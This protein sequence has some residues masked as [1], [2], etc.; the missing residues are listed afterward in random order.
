MK[1]LVLEDYRKFAYK[2]VP[3]PQIEPENVL[4]RVA[5]CAICGSDVHGMDGSTG[6]RI[7]PVIMG[8]EASGIIEEMG[9][10]VKDFKIGDR[11]TFD[12]NV[13]CG[14]CRYCR[15]G[16]PNLCESRR[17]LGVSC[18]EYRQDG[19]FAEYLSVP[20]R[21]LCR[22]PDN[23]SFE[24]AAL[25]EPLSIALHAVN[26]TPVK[27]NDNALVIGAGTIGLLIIQILKLM[28]LK[29]I[30][31]VDKD[32]AR[33]DM[34]CGLGG[35][36]G[37]LADE[38]DIAGSIFGL[39]GGIGADVVF[40]AVGVSSSVTCAINCVKKGGFVTLVGNISPKVE[41]PL[42]RIV[43]GE[44]LISGSCQSTGEY[45]ACLDLMRRNSVDVGKIISAVAPLEEGAAWFERLYSKQPGLMKVILKP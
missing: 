8:H 22:L 14:R 34:A 39:T 16:C 38:P 45:G 28:G 9:H 19:A 5:A 37:V 10:A 33:L 21:I 20:E 13:Y 17:V 41:V 6:R 35:V 40:E 32:K 18:G 1:A 29:L 44:I 23:V 3:M 27:V 15:L 43:T 26:I 31:V 11:V 36:P 7:P 25:V 30:I 24:H 12:S 2:D 42:Q 4:I